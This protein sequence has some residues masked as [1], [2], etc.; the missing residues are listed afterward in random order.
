MTPNHHEYTIPLSPT[1]TQ[2]RALDA[3]GMLTPTASS[4]P[5]CSRPNSA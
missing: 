1:P 5:S 3:L 2:E 4:A